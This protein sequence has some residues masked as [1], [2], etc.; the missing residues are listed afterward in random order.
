MLED[1]QDKR[2]AGHVDDS[3]TVVEP[4]KEGEVVIALVPTSDAE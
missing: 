1:M 2:E 3:K 4:S